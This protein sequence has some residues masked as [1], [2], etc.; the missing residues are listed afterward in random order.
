MTVR[1]P[2]HPHTHTQRNTN[3]ACQGA[4]HR[5]HVLAERSL[6]AFKINEQWKTLYIQHIMF[7]IKIKII[8]IIKIVMMIMLGLSAWGI[9]YLYLKYD[10]T[11]SRFLSSALCILP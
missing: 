6:G 3:Y 2:L 10:L 1:Q 9:R 4:W 8:I 7:M 5:G 11:I